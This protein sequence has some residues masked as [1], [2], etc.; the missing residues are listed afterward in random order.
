MA[1]AKKQKDAIPEMKPQLDPNELYL[2]DNGHV[3]CGKLHC[4]GSSAHFTGRCISGQAVDRITAE[5]LREAWK[6]YKWVPECET[7]GRKV[8]AK[9][10][11]KKGQ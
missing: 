11:P 9:K 3:F 1:R 6:L 10:P 2:G 4:A 7:C 5:Y 8:A